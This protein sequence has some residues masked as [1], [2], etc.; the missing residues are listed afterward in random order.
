MQSKVVNI[1]VRFNQRSFI[2]AV[3]QTLV[4][5]FPVTLIGAMAQLVVKSCLDANGFF[6]ISLGLVIGCP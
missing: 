2:Q 3:R 6:I 1:L 5:L 4:V